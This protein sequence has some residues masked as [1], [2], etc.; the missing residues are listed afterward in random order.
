MIRLRHMMTAVA[1]ALPCRV[2]KPQAAQDWHLRVVGEG[3]AHAW[4]EGLLRAARRVGIFYHPE[5]GRA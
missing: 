4:N 3:A 2:T 1:A 5:P